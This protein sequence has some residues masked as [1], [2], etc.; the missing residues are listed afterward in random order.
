MK[1]YP[2][3]TNVKEHGKVAARQ[4]YEILNARRTESTLKSV[5]NID[6]RFIDDKALP[7]DNFVLDEVEHVRDNTYSLH[8]SIDYFI[9][10][11]CKDMNLEDSFPTTIN[12]EVYDD[13]LNFDVID[14]NRDTVD[15]F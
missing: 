9:F 14:N 6:L 2:I 1:Q 4:L 11:L 7:S 8:Y 10:N 3:T 5:L 13:H 12:F 15:E